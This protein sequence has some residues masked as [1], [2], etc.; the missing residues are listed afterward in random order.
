MKLQPGITSVGID[1]TG[2][3]Y[4]VEELPET[5]NEGDTCQLCWPG[6]SGWY[7]SWYIWE[8]GQWHEEGTTAPWQLFV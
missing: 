1:F 4:Q 2:A 8:N 7:Q 5:A 6:G 3:E